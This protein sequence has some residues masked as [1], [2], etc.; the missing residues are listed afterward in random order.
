[1]TT[2]YSEKLRDPRWQKKRLEILN[3]DEWECRRCLDKETTLHVHHVY[4]EDG[5]EPW[6]YPD[7]ALVTLCA[8][9]HESE[10]ECLPIMVKAMVMELKR[11]GANAGTF[12]ALACAFEPLHDIPHIGIDTWSV[13]HVTEWHIRQMVQ[14]AADD[15]EKWL[16]QY[17][18]PYIQWRESLSPK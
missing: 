18:K 14:L 15:P 13:L 4:Y 2:T 8:T 12:E 1:M 16:E 3:R 10:T 5:K 17:H 6:E 9:C 11:A 7:K